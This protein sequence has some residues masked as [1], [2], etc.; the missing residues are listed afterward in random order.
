V[1]LSRA[2]RR[3]EHTVHRRAAEAL[4]EE[5]PRTLVVP[6]PGKHGEL[7]HLVATAELVLVEWGYQFDRTELPYEERP[8]TGWLP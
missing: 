7:G 1:K 2:S 3:W 4:A 6:I 5:R 8:K